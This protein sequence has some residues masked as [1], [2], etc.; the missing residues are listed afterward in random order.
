MEVT[1][2]AVVEVAVDVTV[3]DVLLLMLNIGDLSAMSLLDFE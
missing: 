2:K 3:D 1:V